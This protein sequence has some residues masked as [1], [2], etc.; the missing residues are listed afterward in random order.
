MNDVWAAGLPAGLG[1]ILGQAVG[2]VASPWPSASVGTS[3][4]P[5]GGVP[6][7]HD[8][9][10]RSQL[11]QADGRP[12]G[13]LDAA[14]APDTGLARSRRPR[15]GASRARAQRAGARQV[16]ITEHVEKE[17]RPAPRKPPKI[18]PPVAEGGEK[19]ARIEKGE[20]AAPVRC[21]GHRR[22]AAAGIAGRAGQDPNKGYSAEALEALSRLLELKLADFRHR[23]RGRGG[24]PRAGDHPLRDPA[25][26][27]RQGQRGSN[28]AK[29]LARSLAVISVRVVEVIPGKSWSASRFPTRTASWSTCARC[30]PPKPS[31]MPIAA[32]P[33]ARQGHL[34]SAG[35]GRPRRDA[36]PAGRRHHRLGQ[37]RGRQRDAAV[38]CSTRR[39]PRGA[40]DPG[41][42]EDARAVGLRRHSAPADAGGHRHEGGGQRPALVRGRDGAALQAD[43]RPGVRNLAGF[44]RKV[45]TRI[46]AGEPIKIR[47]G[48][49][50]RLFEG[51]RRGADGRRSPGA[52]AL[53]SWW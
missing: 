33:G 41:R 27:G 29:D 16:A 23:G 47:C 9:V 15:A 32:D 12:L 34:R 49:P 24:A 52:A 30:S 13:L 39:S 48:S 1:G 18:K 50:T 46:K 5:A 8:R 37:V 28:L 20:A 43:G 45:R 42:S 25:G 19:R 31:T 40:A 17:K 44:N 36:A 38:A 35:G 11:D 7:R 14:V 51:G 21:A 53:S 4:D 2:G 22:I 26:A 3:P 6:V 10:H